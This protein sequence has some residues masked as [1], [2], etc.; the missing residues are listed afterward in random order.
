LKNPN[1]IPA[2]TVSLTTSAVKLPATKPAVSVVI[3]SD[4]A[5]GLEAGWADLRATL[6]ALAQQDF[7]EPVEFIL[8]ESAELASQ[9]PSDFATI[10]PALRV[11]SVPYR[12]SAELKNAAVE[13]ASTELVAMLDGDCAPSADWLRQIVGAMRM[14]PEAAVISGRTV[15]PGKGLIHRTMGAV[16][17]SFVDVGHAGPNWHISTNNALYRRSA[18]LAH[19]LEPDVGAFGS[20]L[21]SEAILRSGGRL[22]FEPLARVVHAYEGWATERNFRRGF[23]YGVIRT[24]RVDPRLPYA[25]L[26]R[27][28]Y[29]SI[30]VFIGA[31]ILTGWWYCLSRGRDH[32]VVWYELPFAFALVA[33]ACC[34]ETPGMLSALRNQAGVDTLFR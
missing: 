22:L 4:Y 11:I 16:N 32:G 15:H 1:E 20:R 2:S 9:I 10:L 18:F 28:G 34:M 21:Q 17:R 3:I 33:I 27:L 30:P 7:E 25:W 12:T 6:K 5:T 8:V 31:H 26:T 23:G 19:P 29:L 24:R 13:A 14:H